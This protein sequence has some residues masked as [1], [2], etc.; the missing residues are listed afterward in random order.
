MARVVRVEVEV[1]AEVEE[2]Q[3]G[4]QVVA[5]LAAGVRAWTSMLGLEGADLRDMRGK[6]RAVVEV[7]GIEDAVVARLR[8]TELAVVF[9][10]MR[11]HGRRK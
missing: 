11:I 3:P 2:E 4:T 10:Q 7:L 5:G 6:G 8:M 1:E 9:D